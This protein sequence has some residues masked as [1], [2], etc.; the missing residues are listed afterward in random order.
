[1]LHYNGVQHWIKW[2]S[3]LLMI[4]F[5]VQLLVIPQGTLFG[6]LMFV[7]SLGASWLHNMYLSSTDVKWQTDILLN[8]LRP[9]VEPPP[10][11]MEKYKFGTRIAAVVFALFSLQVKSEDVNEQL[12]RLLP[13]ST[14]ERRIWKG[15]VSST[16]RGDA[17]P[18]SE[19]GRRIWMLQRMSC[20]RLCTATL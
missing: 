2:C 7:T 16:L 17:Q 8:I 5:L 9:K 14:H 20:W 19:A 3:L 4:Q 6:Q 13:N 15:V 10:Q 1:M 12:V 18:V 11:P